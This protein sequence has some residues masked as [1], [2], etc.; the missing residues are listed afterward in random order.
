VRDLEQLILALGERERLQA[1][2][3]RV[4]DSL[5]LW[6]GVERG[7]LLLRAPNGTLQPRAARNLS[8]S[9]LSGEQRHLSMSLAQQA[10]RT[11]DCVV[12]VDASGELASFHESVHALRLRS[13]L[14]VPLS[15]KNETLGVVYLDDR[16]RAGAFGADEM[17]WA[18]LVAS[19][20]AVAILDARSQ[21]LLRRAARKAERRTVE[22]SKLLDEAQAELARTTRE[23]ERVKS[24]QNR[25][26]FAS[27]FG[28]SDQ[29]LRLLSL[30]ERVAHSEVPVLI[31]GE[32]GSGKELVARSLHSLSPRQSRPFVAENCSAIPETLLESALFGHVKGAF[33]G[34]SLA[35][36]G[37]FEQADGGTLFLDEI[38]DMPLAMQAKLLRV[39]ESGELRRLGSERSTRVNVRVVGASHQDLNE[40]VK[41]GR[42]REDLLYRLNVITLEVPAL[43]NRTGDVAVLVQHFLKKYAGTSPKALHPDTLRALQVYAWPG[44]VRQLE[45]EIR[46][47]LVLSDEVIR[48]EHLSD[49][50]RAQAGAVTYAGLELKPRVDALESELI[51][52]ALLE[53]GN[54]QTKA[55]QL[56]GVS[57]FGLQKMLKRLSLPRA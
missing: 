40:L 49:A 22:K 6:T 24:P 25:D 23:L 15:A 18:K 11:N 10:Y 2:L 38:A 41:Q 3:V 29:L 19:L 55:A 53:A 4:V 16:M 32:S 47:A 45:N 42:F 44:N 48:P 34:A 33:T 5:V 39:I 20:A 12:A 31:H 54:N 30:V 14:A 9:D 28:Q 37:L 17:A 50:L 1:L 52:R 43:R 46:R 21:L 13:V 26:K 51:S 35:R 36:A 27:I 57:R 56:L 8:R 7:L